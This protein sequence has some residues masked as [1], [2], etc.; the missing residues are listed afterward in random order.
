MP[1]LSRTG[2]GHSPAAT[3]E[4]VDDAPDAEPDATAGE[5][6]SDLVR[7]HRDAIV[8][9]VTRAT[10]NGEPIDEPG[11][12][13]LVL[14]RLVA[15]EEDPGRLATTAASVANAIVRAD[16]A[17][18]DALEAARRELPAVMMEILLEIAAAKDIPGAA[19]I[20]LTSEGAQP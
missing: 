11:L 2:A 14:A 8:A 4:P 15:H 12:L 9:V 6:W 18:R 3:F 10:A 1:D 17:S 20:D 7:R 19:R 13:R 5:P 16:S